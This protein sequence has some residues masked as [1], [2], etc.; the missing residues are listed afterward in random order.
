MGKKEKPIVSMS[1]VER[2]KMWDELLIKEDGI[3]IEYNPAVMTGKVRSVK[4]DHIYQIY[5][6]GLLKMKIELH[7]GEK[8]LFAP[9]DDSEGKKDF[10][11]VMKIIGS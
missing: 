6:S 5:S 3:I 8:V 1:K 4:D 7:I 2:K 9:I 11:R 10:A